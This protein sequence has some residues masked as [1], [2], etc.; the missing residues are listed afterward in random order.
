M[1]ILQNLHQKVYRLETIVTEQKNMF[2]LTEKKYVRTVEVYYLENIDERHQFQILVVDF[3]FSNDDNAEGILIKQISYLFD[4]LEIFV[5]KE[6][7]IIKIG[8]LDFLRRRWIKIS[9]KLLLSHKGETIDNYFAQISNLL[10]NEQ[11]LIDFLSGYQ[12][13]GLL[14]NGLLNSF[15]NKTSRVSA[16]G[17]AEI[18]KVKNHSDKTMITISAD[19]IE[20]TGI[21]DFSGILQYRNDL[22]EE[23]FIEIKK[24]NYHLKHSLLW[25]G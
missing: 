15:Q 16:E 11:Q 17:F 22:Y 23:G 4:E 3:N 7:N 18:L 6:G 10:E 21:K 24:H 13:F 9:G 2:Y 19:N 25:I 1:G 12:M 20:N 5:D 14:F 8:N